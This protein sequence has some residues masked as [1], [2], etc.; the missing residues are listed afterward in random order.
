MF[1]SGLRLQE[2][3]GYLVYK[4]SERRGEPF[5]IEDLL[6]PSTS[7]NITALV[8]GKRYPF[9]DAQRQ[10]LDERLKR[11]AGLVGSRNLSAFLPSWLLRIVTRI[12]KLRVGE[13]KRIFDELLEFSR[14]EIKEHAD[15]MDEYSN[16]DFIDAYLKKIKEEQGNPHS[17]FHSK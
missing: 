11:V 9:E 8:F 7:N 4:I 15:T 3:A 14:K 6:V 16:R 1:F 17:S 5:L 13:A 12:P 10:F 2:E